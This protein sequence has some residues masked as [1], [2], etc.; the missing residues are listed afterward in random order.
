MVE[1]RK[2]ED[3]INWKDFQEKGMPLNDH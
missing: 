2:G 1:H 3:Y